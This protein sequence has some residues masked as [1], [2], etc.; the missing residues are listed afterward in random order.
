[1]KIPKCKICG[2]KMIKSRF[3]EFG[4]ANPLYYCPSHMY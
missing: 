4:M 2:K 1:M 3:S